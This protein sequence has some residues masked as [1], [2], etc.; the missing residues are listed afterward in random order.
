MYNK[1][2]EMVT[3]DMSIDLSETWIDLWKNS[4]DFYLD[5]WDTA[6][7][8][9]LPTTGQDFDPDYYIFHKFVHNG[10]VLDR[11]ICVFSN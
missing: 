11:T 7:D 3:T 10:W 2:F 8:G 9:I 1:K 6:I 5:A 4:R